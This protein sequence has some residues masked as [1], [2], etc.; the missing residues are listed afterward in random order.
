MRQ[1]TLPGP[2]NKCC[3]GWQQNHLIPCFLNLIVFHILLFHIIFNT[4]CNFSYYIYKLYIFILYLIVSLI[5]F[6][7]ASVYLPITRPSLVVNKPVVNISMPIIA[8]ASLGSR[9][10]Y[11]AWE[12]FSSLWPRFYIICTASRV[13]FLLRTEEPL[14]H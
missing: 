6:Y 4:I 14:Q 2:L 5:L 8:V 10:V 9:K 1:L 3:I 13:S 7:I 11:H 12:C